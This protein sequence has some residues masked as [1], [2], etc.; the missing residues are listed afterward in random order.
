MRVIAV[1]KHRHLSPTPLAH[2]TNQRSFE[3]LREFGLE[4]PALAL[5]TSYD[6]IPDEIFMRS[7]V[8]P[9]FGEATAAGVNLQL[10]N[11]RPQ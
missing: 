5:A 1:S 2:R 4:W 3:I 9:E 7:P 6:D 11:R 8:G 10:L